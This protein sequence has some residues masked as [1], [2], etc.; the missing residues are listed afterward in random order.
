MR[1][2]EDPGT[3]RQH[4][5]LSAERGGMETRRCTRISA[6]VQSRSCFAVEKAVDQRAGP[7]R[8]PMA[9]SVEP[10]TSISS[11]GKM[12]FIPM[13]ATPWRTG[14]TTKTP[15]MLFSWKRKSSRKAP[16]T[17][18]GAPL[19]AVRLRPFMGTLALTQPR[20]RNQAKASSLKTLVT[21]PVS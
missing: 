4:R 9:T 13:M 3:F 5:T 2:E 10:G 11:S 19:A 21:A 17:A 6:T 14:T 15:E 20:D 12:I 7:S 18:K 16:M 1:P 8:W